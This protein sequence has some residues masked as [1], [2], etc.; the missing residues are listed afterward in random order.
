LP[1]VKKTTLL[2]IVVL[3]ALVAAGCGS[4]GSSSSSGSSTA[5]SSAT[6]AP[7][8]TP[9]PASHEAPSYLQGFQAVNNKFEQSPQIADLSQ[10][11]STA[12]APGAGSK[13]LAAAEAPLSSYLKSLDTY[14]AEL[15]GLHF[16]ACARHFQ[17]QIVR[18]E[19]EGRASVAKILPL[20]HSGEPARVL[21]Y[22]RK[23][24][25]ALSAKLGQV[26][27]KEKSIENGGNDG[28]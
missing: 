4:S 12:T 5:S 21:A 1:V 26:E 19:S 8:T 3:A 15:R 14:I 6:T 2:F 20:L 18:F 25:P 28:C 7:S 13:E 24:A 10:A 27:I 23:A 9:A 16:P 22:V 17:A 11:L